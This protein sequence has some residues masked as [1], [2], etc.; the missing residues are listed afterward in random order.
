MSKVGNY[1]FEITQININY[2]GT[3]FIPISKINELRRELFESLEEKIN[4]EYKHENKNIKLKQIKNDKTSEK[5]NLS[6]Y[7]IEIGRASCRERV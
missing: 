6:Y 3:L 1:P 5:I 4:D 7:M 2:D